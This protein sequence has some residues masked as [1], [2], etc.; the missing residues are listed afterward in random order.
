MS[1]VHEAAARNTSEQV[2]THEQLKLDV[3]E[4]C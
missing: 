4:L 2:T 3:I 1:E